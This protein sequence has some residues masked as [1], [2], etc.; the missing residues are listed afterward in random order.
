MPGPWY[1]SDTASLADGG[2][3][4]PSFC[5][6]VWQIPACLEPP[7]P[8]HLD[9]STV[10]GTYRY[11]SAGT[12][13]GPLRKPL[14]YPRTPLPA[15]TTRVDAEPVR[16]AYPSI[17]ET[18]PNPGDLAIPMGGAAVGGHVRPRTGRSDTDHDRRTL[19]H[20]SRPPA[21]AVTGARA[22]G[23]VVNPPPRP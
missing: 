17:D 18:D 10:R 4:E 13:T 3:T 16:V 11:G 14:L 22:S 9:S 21:D 20:R 12:V 8:R 19:I 1:G 2:L 5:E 7:D 23:R 15:G 6:G